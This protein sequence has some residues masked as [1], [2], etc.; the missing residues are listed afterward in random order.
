MQTNEGIGKELE[1]LNER[2]DVLLGKKQE[3]IGGITRGPEGNLI[4]DFDAMKKG[5]EKERQEKENAFNE[6]M[7]KYTEKQIKKREETNEL[8]AKALISDR[9]DTEK[10]RDIDIKLEKDKAIKEVEERYESRG[11]KSEQTK[12]IDEAYRNLSKGLE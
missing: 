1:K 11:V 8:F 9:E 7:S 6:Q 12:K 2:M 3:K 4:I 10:K 5:A